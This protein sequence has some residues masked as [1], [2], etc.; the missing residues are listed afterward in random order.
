M[1]LSVLSVE[2]P[3]PSLSVRV[4]GNPGATAHP[5]RGR[6]DFDPAASAALDFAD[7]SPALDDCVSHK[8]TTLA[9]GVGYC[10]RADGV[11]QAG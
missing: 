7:H 8:V 1:S 3:V 4:H 9:S 2:I 10:C 5:A 6:P 11:T